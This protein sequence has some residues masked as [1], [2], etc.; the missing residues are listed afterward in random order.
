MKHTTRHS[1]PPATSRVTPARWRVQGLLAV[2]TLTAVLSFMAPPPAAA[3]AA[4][5]APAPVAAAPDK[6]VTPRT[7]SLPAK[8]LF[9]GDQLSDLAKDKLTDLVIN[10]LGLDVEVALIV[11]TGPWSLEGGNNDERNLTEAR[12]GAVRKFLTDRGVES[13]RIFVESRIDNS[14]KEPRLDVQLLGRPATN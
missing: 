5:P 2:S 3:Q 13:K 7:A 8:G 12:L 10:A 9:K 1:H 6:T 14:I 4:R 11:P